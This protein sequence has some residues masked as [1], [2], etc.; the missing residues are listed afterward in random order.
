MDTPWT[1]TETSASGQVFEFRLLQLLTEQSRGQ[2]HVF[3]PLTDRGIDALVHRLQDD[4]Y[5]QVQAKS[6]STFMDG[7]VHIVVWAE[8]LV[9]DRIL[10]VSG[11][12]VD[13]GLG[14]T[15]LLIPASDF[16]RQAFMSSNEGR[17]IY[18]AE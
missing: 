14:P 18:S 1:R 4:I 10:I 7:E 12:V 2:L 11:L 8:S 13:G 3:L 6:R 15:C 9:D 17:P 16:K 5:F